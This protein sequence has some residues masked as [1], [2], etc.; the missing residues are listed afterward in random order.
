MEMKPGLYQHQIMKMTMTQE[1]SQAIALLQYSNQE[2]L[3]YLETKWLENP[4]LTI[5]SSTVSHEIP[6][7]PLKRNQVKNTGRSTNWIEQIGEEAPSL[8]NHLLS[9]IDTA[10]FKKMELK[11]F[12]HLIR[13]IDENGY[14]RINVEEAAVSI[15]ISESALLK[16]LDILQQLEPYGIGARSLQECLLIQVCQAGERPLAETL[17]RTYFMPFVDKKWKEISRNLGVTLKEIQDEFDY[18]Q[19]LN[20][21]PG[22]IF[23][24]EKSSYIVPDVV[25]KY[26]DGQLVVGQYEGDTLQLHVN[27][28]YL[29]KMKD[30]QDPTVNRFLQEKW[31]EYQWLSK[32]ILQRKE[33][34]LHV[35]KKIVEKQPEYFFRGMGFLKPMTMKEIAD[36]LDIHESTVSRAVR[37]KY[38]QTAFGTVEMRSFFSS[39]L[40]STEQ[41]D[42]SGTK[43]RKALQT[44]V[45]LE[46]KQKPHSDQELAEILKNEH[47]F[48]LSRRTVAKY[49]DQLGILSSSKRKR[50]K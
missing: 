30:H 27:E 7:K 4:L 24:S 42:V 1:L 26:Q 40:Q 35:M 16:S 43:V 2:L 5:E 50:Y 45:E 22:A 9:Q 46:N 14:L 37:S 28:S 44:I 10:T 18:I 15:G 17:L 31:Q 19:T 49:R 6:R 39:A 11:S 23:S 3:E 48:V 38:V 36:D 41:E 25:V 12:I 21:R 34:V 47:G 8:E 33:T 20:P 13:N 32:G 29:R